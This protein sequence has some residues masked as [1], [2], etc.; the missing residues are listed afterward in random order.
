[1]PANV[2]SL[3][4]LR[5]LDRSAAVFPAKSRSAAFTHRAESRLVGEDG[6]LDVNGD[7]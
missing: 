2:R 6:A 1:M 5:F 7:H 4:P 3:T